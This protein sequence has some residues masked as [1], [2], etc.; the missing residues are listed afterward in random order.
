MKTMYNK[1]TRICI[2]VMGKNKE[3]VLAQASGV[4]SQN[5]DI[6]EWRMDYLDNE[7]YNDVLEGLHNILSDIPLIVTFRTSAEGGEK[8]I[9][10]KKYCENYIQIAEVAKDNNVEFIDI[11]AYRIGEESKSLITKIQNYGI[12]IIGSNHN[13]K[14]TPSTEKMVNILCEI[15]ELGADVSKMAVMPRRG[16]DITKLIRAS[17]R[18][19]KATGKP[20]ITMAMG[21]LGSITRVCTGLTNSIITFAAGVDAS[22]PGQVGIDVVR[23]LMEVTKGCEIN[24]NLALIGFMGSGK[25]T[26]SNALSKITGFKEVDV[27]QYIVKKAGMPISEIF[28]KYGEEYFRK[29]ETQALKELQN[30]QGQIISCGGGAVLKDENVEILKSNSLIVRLEATPET[31]FERVKDSTTRPLLN[32]NMSIERVKELMASREPRYSSVADITVNVDVNNRVITCYDLLKKLEEVY[33]F[34]IEHKN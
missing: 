32:G 29:L 12:K 13:F 10:Y 16:Y 17:R 33:Y 31:I 4:K 1:E 21:E 2:P 23:Y 25:T 3:E 30:R 34:K 9:S 14:K 15:S 8:E 7:N 24:G 20:I 19:K 27:D 5:P 22:A 18:A 28:K 11:E 6:V 26:I